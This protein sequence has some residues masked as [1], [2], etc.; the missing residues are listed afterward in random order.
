MTTVFGKII[1]GELPADIVYSNEWV[2]AFKDR[3]PTAPV[4]ILICPRKEIASLQELKEEDFPLMGEIVKA[5]QHL[6]KE[7]KI[8]EGYRLITNVGESSG[9]SIFH[10]HFHLVGGRKLGRLA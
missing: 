8:E 3:A 7:F 9:Q 4:H 6:A 1:A 5:A 10:L 2:V